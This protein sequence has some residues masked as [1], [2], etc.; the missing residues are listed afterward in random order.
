MIILPCL[1]FFFQGGYLTYV[2][3]LM[4]FFGM[5]FNITRWLR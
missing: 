3:L 2:F 1:Q 5:I 4:F